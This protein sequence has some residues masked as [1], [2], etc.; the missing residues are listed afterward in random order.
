MPPVRSGRSGE[1][2]VLVAPRAVS[3]SS[4]EPEDVRTASTAASG[5]P[6]NRVSST[7][8]PVLSGALGASGPSAR[9]LAEAVSNRATDNAS[10]ETTVKVFRKSWT[11]NDGKRIKLQVNNQ[12]R[13]NTA[14]SYLR[15]SSSLGF[16]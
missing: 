5:P 3:A 7:S 10:Q 8:V 15:H 9:R 11:F 1:A 12:T 13:L 4:S 14:F 16:S 2:G 6:Q